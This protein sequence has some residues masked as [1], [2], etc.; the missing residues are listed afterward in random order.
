MKKHSIFPITILT[1]AL[2]LTGC[3]RSSKTTSSHDSAQ[4]DTTTMVSVGQAK[5]TE[6]QDNIENGKPYVD[7]G[8]PSGTKWATCNIGADSPSE[9]GILLQWGET[10]AF[11]GS[12]TAYNQ[13]R[14]NDKQVK[15]IARSSEYDAAAII[16]GDQWQMP[17]KNDF[18]EL[19][20]N[21]K[22]TFVNNKSVPGYELKGPNGNTIF[23]PC[24]GTYYEMECDPE[25]D[26][27]AYWT[28]TPHETD[29]H[30]SYAVGFVNPYNIEEG[31]EVSVGP[32]VAGTERH[33]G[34]SVRPVIK[35]KP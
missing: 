16:W 18:E 30:L 27:G 20:N 21:C 9:G 29:G 3:S 33:F 11:R 1:A 14:L 32:N 6:V 28:S 10:T 4:A 34:L 17:S 7:L 22:W 2:T 8:L 12:D 25:G 35:K 5:G 19:I 23:L 31:E 13:C 26:S 15:D 24:A